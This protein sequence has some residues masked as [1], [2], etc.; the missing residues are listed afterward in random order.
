MRKIIAMLL[1]L[2]LSLTSAA[3]GNG[4]KS[5]IPDGTFVKSGTTI[6]LKVSK[7]S[8][9]VSVPDYFGK[10]EK[11]M[12]LIG[13]AHGDRGVPVGILNALQWLISILEI[14]LIYT[15]EERI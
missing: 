13:K 11:S 9:F 12:S 5:S 3:C 14:Q 4:A 8:K 10:T 15:A 6:E 1:L 7:G 2:S